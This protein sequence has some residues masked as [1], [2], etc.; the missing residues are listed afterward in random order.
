ML[1]I[2]TYFSPISQ[3]VALFQNDEFIFEVEDNYQKQTYRNH[4]NI[5]G[6]N[7]KLQLNIPI[8][9]S[10]KGT[11]QKTKDIRID[12]SER[13]QQLHLRSIQTA[14]RSSP[15]FEF[16]EDDLLPLYEG[17]QKFLQDFNLKCH[18]FL[19]DALQENIPF[20]KTSEY[21]ITPK[22]KDMR[23][24]ANARKEATYNFKKYTQVFDDRYG[25]IPNLSILDLLF[26]EG[27]NS[28]TY[29]QEQTIS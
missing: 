21:E 29:L 24:L 19:M 25:Y 16:Y 27:P 22:T 17:N 13:W 5:Y 23:F 28:V 26:M 18:E 3:Y 8:V 1:F 12:Q 10:K 9:H 4:C 11:R 15:Y 7:G 6:A 2:P 20:T 14:Y